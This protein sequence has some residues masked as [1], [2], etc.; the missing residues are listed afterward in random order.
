MSKSQPSP[1][2]QLTTQQ[3]AAELGITPKRVQ[4]L[5]TERRLPA[6]RFGWAWVI[7][8]GDLELVRDRPHGVHRTGPKANSDSG[9]ADEKPK[10]TKSDAKKKRS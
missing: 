10:N 1:D 3:V 6:T 9:K 8:R 4:V 2:E 5:I 7:R